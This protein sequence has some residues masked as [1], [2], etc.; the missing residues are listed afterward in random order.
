MADPQPVIGQREKFVQR[1]ELFAWRTNIERAGNLQSAD[2][3]RPGKQQVIVAPA[4]ADFG[5]QLVTRRPFGGPV[6]GSHRFLDQIH[7]MR[8]VPGVVRVHEGHA[9]GS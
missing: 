5:N 3:V 7:R 8:D 1:R 4:S 6:A 9:C 2:L